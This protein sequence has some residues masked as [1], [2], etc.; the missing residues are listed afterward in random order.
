MR[1]YISELRMT[2]IHYNYCTLS[3]NPQMAVN[4][5]Q[6]VTTQKIPEDKQPHSA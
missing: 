1:S 5:R 3:R 4:T 2:I 6:G